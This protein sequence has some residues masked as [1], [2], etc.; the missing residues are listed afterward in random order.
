M[1]G[2]GAH[3][4]PA[5]DAATII[6]GSGVYRT[7]LSSHQRVPGTQAGP[8][9]VSAAVVPAPDVR[10]RPLGD[11]ERLNPETRGPEPIDRALA[12]LDAASRFPRTDEDLDTARRNFDRLIDTLHADALVQHIWETSQVAA[13]RAPGPRPRLA[14]DH[15]LYDLAFQVFLAKGNLDDGYTVALAATEKAPQRLDWAVR[16]AQVAE[17]SQRPIVALETWFALAGKTGRR[18]YW[19]HVERLALGLRD[20]N[21]YASYLLWRLRSHPN[22]MATLVRLSETYERQGDPAQAIRMLQQVIPTLADADRRKLL[23]YLSHLADRAGDAQ[24]LVDTLAQAER[25]FGPDPEWAVRMAGSQYSRG[26]A[27]LA[28]DALRRA[29]DVARDPARHDAQREQDTGFW[30]TYANLANELQQRGEAIDAYAQMLRLGTY[31]REDIANLAQALVPR[32]PEA[33]ADAFSHGYFR[34][35]DEAMARQALTLW[36][37]AGQIENSTAFLDRLPAATRRAIVSSSDF[38]RQ[39]SAYY[40]SVDRFGDALADLVQIHR[41]DP[42]DMD[43]RAAMLWL[44]LAKRDAPRLRA[45]LDRW[46]DV[47]RTEPVLW[48]PYGASLLALDEPEQALPYFVRQA[49]KSSDYLWWLAYADALNVVGHVDA[50]WQLRRRAWTELRKSPNPDQPRGLGERERVVALAL[51]F[52]PA[53]EANELLRSLMRDRLR[54]ADP[55]TVPTQPGSQLPLPDGEAAGQPGALALGNVLTGVLAQIAANPQDPDPLLR[56]RNISE[57]N[58]MRVAASELA[59]SYLLSQ[60]ANDAARG[61]LMSRYAQDLVKPAWAELSMAL[62]NNDGEQL[63]H[64]LA[65]VADWLPKLDQVQA[66]ARNGHFGQAQ[67]LAFDTAAARPN[68][69]SAHQVL[70]DQMLAGGPSAGITSTRASEDAYSR[71]TTRMDAAIRLGQHSRAY[72]FVERDEVTSRDAALLRDPGKPGETIGV[73]FDWLRHEGRW[74]AEIARRDAQADGTPVRVRWER[75]GDPILSLSATVGLAQPANDSAAMVAGGQKDLVEVSGQYNLTARN[76][77]AGQLEVARLQTQ[78]GTGIGRANR[79]GVEF[80]HRLR[81]EYPDLTLRAVLGYADYTRNNSADPVIARLAPS[82]AA[83][84]VSLFVPASSTQMDLFLTAGSS[85]RDSYTRGLRPFGE[86]GAHYNTDAGASMSLRAG[87]STSLLGTDRL[88]LF[89][90]WKSKSTS[91]PGGNTEFGLAY[92][93]HY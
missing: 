67:T 62:A 82:G 44:T 92:R 16:L 75:T 79:L 40:Q 80:G 71:Q 12:T 34:F 13:S 58:S 51:Q 87:L 6:A 20:E 15:E 68:N 86:I 14:F 53:D 78:L 45:M 7:S 32:S 30:S 28:L 33:A 49:R 17:W 61:W 90:A 60:E 39:R 69:D 21:R 56:G 81:L 70:V 37:R 77:L 19:S 48:G 91:S 8:A 73:G 59:V 2:E 25:E 9:R 1:L 89:G 4:S 10:V 76:Y 35:E 52:S 93:L 63:D 24:L 85:I 46:R 22:D 83:D 27:L 36:L 29:A 65:T 18:E 88:T 11:D 26:R 23:V 43:N 47:A 31:E 72:G 50:A 3:A 66:M 5:P 84:P 74:S 41:N 38:L 57:V 55:A 54:L 42:N 64:L